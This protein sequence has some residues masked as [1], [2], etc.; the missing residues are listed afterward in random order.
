MVPTWIERFPDSTV[1]TP[2]HPSNPQLPPQ[3][4]RILSD[5]P[6]IPTPTAPQ[7][8]SL[9]VDVCRQCLAFDS[10]SALLACLEAVATDPAAKVARVTECGCAC[11]C[12]CM[13]V[14]VCLHA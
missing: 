12:V 13:R 8:V 3:A 7:D 9:V 2:T 10:P 5:C 11:A 1:T 4:F 14:R 6:P